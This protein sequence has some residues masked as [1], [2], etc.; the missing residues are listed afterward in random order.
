MPPNNMY[1]SPGP[2]FDPTQPI[3]K[4]RKHLN[5]LLVPLVLTVLLLMGALGFGGWA[6]VSMQ[7]YKN[8]SDKK[9]DV[10]VQIA[11]EENTAE[12]EAAFA[13][14][15]KEPLKDY[16]GP[17]S[18]GSVAI[19]Y[20]KTWSAFITELDKGGTPV[21]GYFHPNYVPGLQS[22]TSFALHLQV[23][24]LVYADELKKFDSDAKAGRVKVTAIAVDN[25]PG[26]TGV[27]IDGEIERGKQ[28][29]LVLLPMRDK[30]LKV[31]TETEQ[32]KND[33]N[34]IIL[35]HLSFIP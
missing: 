27:R 35:K 11:K 32:F 1:P 4:S 3:K 29:S 7:D 9:V 14:R 6:F 5:G 13:E 24:S 33:F 34:T 23:T 15:E 28:G 8:N 17:A 18:F 21:D 12:N 20:P 2:T 19:K 10:A 31:S 16:K 22:G 26:V 25:V 30:T